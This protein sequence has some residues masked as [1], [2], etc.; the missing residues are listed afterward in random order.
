MRDTANNREKVQRIAIENTGIECILH[1][2]DDGLKLL[3]DISFEI[4]CPAMGCGFDP[5]VLRYAAKPVKKRGWTNVRNRL[6]R[7][8][9]TKT[10]QIFLH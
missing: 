1:S 3:D 5:R 2:A 6:S 9:G 7:R 4:N 8:N 10:G